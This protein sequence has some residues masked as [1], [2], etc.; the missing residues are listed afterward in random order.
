MSVLAVHRYMLPPSRP[1]VQASRWVSGSTRCGALLDRGAASTALGGAWLKKS[2]RR[3]LKLT[4]ARCGRNQTMRS[5]WLRPAFSL[6]RL[7]ESSHSVREPRPPVDAS[8]SYRGSRQALGHRPPSLRRLHESL[9]KCPRHR[10]ARTAVRPQPCRCAT[11]AVCAEASVRR[12]QL[13]LRWVPFGGMARELV[14]VVDQSSTSNR[15]S[16][17]C[18]RRRWR[19][20]RG[21]ALE[22]SRS[23]R[24]G[25]A[26]A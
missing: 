12:A 22:V 21:A 23:R 6:A 26:A 16:A 14:R 10:S 8:A 3:L 2:C 13:P 20:G 18:S 5:S 15:G 19:Y 7:F 11:T 9:R 17:T 1:H 25:L 4:K 24:A